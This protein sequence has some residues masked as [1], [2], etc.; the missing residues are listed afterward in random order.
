MNLRRFLLFI[1][2]LGLVGTAAELLAAGHFETPVQWTPL[3]LIAAAVPAL[4]W[5][6]PSGRP[7]RVVLVLFLISGCVGTVLHNRA[8]MEF[9]LESDPSLS[10][11]A[12]FVK[13]FDSKTPP[14]LAPGT[15]IQLGLLGLAYQ[16]AGK[17]RR[18]G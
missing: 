4:I 13:S 10:G 2:V 18:S 9:Q 16:A 17:T 8:K 7:L 5:Q 1:F 11:W 3:I 12:L 6:T 14:A 15:M